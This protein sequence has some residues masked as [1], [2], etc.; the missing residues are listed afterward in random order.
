MAKNKPKRTK[1]Q[2]IIDPILEIMCNKIEELTKERDNLI[3]E[4]DKL[5]AE[6]AKKMKK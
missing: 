1:D 5:K 3:K 2:L 4:K 6:L